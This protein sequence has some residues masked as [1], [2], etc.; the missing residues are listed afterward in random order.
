MS[1]LSIYDAQIVDDVIYVG[2]R[3]EA[4]NGDDYDTGSVVAF[5]RDMAIVSWDSG[6]RTPAPFG[7]LRRLGQA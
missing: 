2:A 4:G 1:D 3:V 6:V 7:I 5:E